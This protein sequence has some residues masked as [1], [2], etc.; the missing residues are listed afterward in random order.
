M[1][2]INPNGTKHHDEQGKI[3]GSWKGMKK[4]LEQDLLCESLRG[5]VSYHFTKYS[6]YGSSGNCASVSLDGQPLKKFGF[7]YADAQLR[8]AGVLSEGQ[9]VWDIELTERDEYED[10]D[11]SHALN[12]Y[13]NQPVEMS[14]ASNN[15]I[16]RMFA[17][18]DRRIGK[19]TLARIRETVDEQPQWLKRLYIARMEAEG[20]GE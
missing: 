2:S 5:R 3:E 20:I 11:F 16:I 7:M 9:H 8:K 14:V 1:E 17:I 6:R 10:W 18:V 13:R 19:R 12:T 15:P 4:K